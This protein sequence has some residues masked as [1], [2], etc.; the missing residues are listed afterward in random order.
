MNVPPSVDY[1]NILGLS[2]C[3][4]PFLN[5]L[6]RNVACEAFALLEVALVVLH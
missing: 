2:L 3:P 4:H 1:C 6:T 5:S